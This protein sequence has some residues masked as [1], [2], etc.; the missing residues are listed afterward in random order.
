MTNKELEQQFI[1]IAKSVAVLEDQIAN[2]RENG[3]ETFNSTRDLKNR[4]TRL[5]ALKA[6]LKQAERDFKAIDNQCSDIDKRLSDRLSDIDKRLSF[7]EKD[8]KRISNVE[9]G[10]KRLESR[11]DDILSRRWE[12]S[13]LILVAVITSILTF[14]LTLAANYIKYQSTPNTGAVATQDFTINE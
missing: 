8:D 14:V 10:L 3:K 4:L 13:K 12:L 6:R 9:E 11:L 1:E 7:V 2:Q 5:E